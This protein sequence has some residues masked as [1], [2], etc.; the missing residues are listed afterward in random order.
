MTKSTE[1]ETSNVE[2]DSMNEAVEEAV[3][4]TFEIL[5][6][7][8]VVKLQAELVVQQ[9]LVEEH[10]DRYK[11]LQADFENLR[12]RTR[13]EKED[14]SMVVAQNILLDL[15]P[16]VDNFERALGSAGTQDAAKVLMGVEMIHRQFIQAL[17]KCGLTTVEALGQLFDPQKHEAVMRVEDETQADG[18]VVEELQ[19]G[20]A[21]RG[22]V[23]R[24]SMVKVVGN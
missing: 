4:K 15:L 10:N 11:R 20:Y 21:V 2:V 17:E 1:K 6:G 14:L 12:R 19:K 24:P 7:D 13:Q 5:D 8:D 18:T 16:V 22:K 3:E 9:R 23:I